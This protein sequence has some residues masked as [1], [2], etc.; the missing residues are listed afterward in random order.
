MT[1]QRWF[2]MSMLLVVLLLTE[3]ISNAQ[4]LTGTLS[5]TVRDESA[6]VLPAASVHLSSPALISGPIS[7]VT[8]EK[9][10]FRF[11]SLAAGDYALDVEMPGFAAYHEDRISI[12]VQGARSGR[13]Y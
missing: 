2:G 11:A 10:Q 4:V 3:R 1:A 13:S 7:M 12:E 9:G 6:G 8:N 5:G